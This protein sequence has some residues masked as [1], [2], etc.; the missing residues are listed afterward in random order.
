[1][2][3]SSC[4][5][6]VRPKETLIIENKSTKAMEIRLFGK[7]KLLESVTIPSNGKFESSNSSN[8]PGG[9][10]NTP[11]N[12]EETDSLIISFEDGKIIRQYCD[13]VLLFGAVSYNPICIWKKN[14]LDFNTGTAT[15]KKFKDHTTKTIT[16]D[17][18]DYAMAI[19]P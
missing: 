6:L 15:K 7:S 4:V 10:D 11:F 5:F 9:F 14:V 13:G 19:E 3:V 1:M 8:S 18:I 2:V 17:E 12:T 16:Y